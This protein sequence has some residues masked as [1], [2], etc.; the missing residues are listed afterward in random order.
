[1]KRTLKILS[2]DSVVLAAL[3]FF[4]AAHSVPF[5]KAQSFS[6]T[7]LLTT[8][9]SLGSMYEAT[10]LWEEF[11]IVRRGDILRHKQLTAQNSPIFADRRFWSAWK[12]TVKRFAFHTIGR[13]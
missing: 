10:P 12:R 3:A 13:G 4:H 2:I 6:G 11:E 8:S 7:G 5:D 1:M 9:I